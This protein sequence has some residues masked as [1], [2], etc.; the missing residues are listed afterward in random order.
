MVQLC[1][2]HLCG[3]RF[4]LRKRIYPNPWR[5]AREASGDITFDQ[6]PADSSVK[7]FT[8]AGKSGENAECR[9]TGKATWDLTN[10]SGDKVASGIYLY[11]ISDNSGNKNQRESL[12]SSVRNSSS[13][14]RGLTYAKYSVVS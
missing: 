8:V 14:Y 11:L 10:D 9:C 3:D 12:R 13:S 6:L 4:H 5:A 1:D 7:L 2:I